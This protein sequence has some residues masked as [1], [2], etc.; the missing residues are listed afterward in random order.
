[1]SLKTFVSDELHDLVGYS[2]GTVADFIVATA[3]RSGSK[4]QLL[5]SLTGTG[6]LSNSGKTQAFVDSLWSQL[7][8]KSGAKTS[9]NRQREQEAV[10][11]QKR[12]ASYALLDDDDDFGATTGAKRPKRK[13]KKRNIRQRGTAPLDVDDDGVNRDK[14]TR[15]RKKKEMDPEEELRLKEE[16]RLRDIA[17]RDALADRLKQKDKDN[18]TNIMVNNSKRALEEARKRMELAEADRAAIVPELRKAARYKYLGERKDIKM[19]ELEA[20]IR[21]E[22]VLF[23]DSMTAAERK[24]LKA[25]KETLRLAKEHANLES[26]LHVDAYAMPEQYVNE[27]DQSWDKKKQMAVLKRR[28]EEAPDDNF[29]GNPEQK[30]WEDDLM[31]M[32]QINTGAK[33]AA[34]MTQQDDYELVMEDMSEMFV[35]AQT[36]GGTIDKD[37][38]PQESEAERRAKSIAEVRKSLPVFGYREAFLKAV[39]EYQILIIVGETGSGKTTQLPQYLVEEGYC[40][41]GKKIG[42][43]QPRRVA[44]MS[45]AARVSEEMGTK[46][47]MDVGYSIRFED[48]TSQRTKLKYMTDGMLLR[49]FLGEP[50][51][52]SY[53]VMM[54][55]EAHERTLHTDILFGLVKDIARFRSDLK[56]LISSAT[57]DAEKFSAYFD[58]APVFR[59]PGR[60]FPVDIFYSKAPEAD[61]LDAAVVT[62]LQ[63]HLSQPL[64]DILV[65]FTGQEEI[66]AAQEQLEEKTRKLGSKI[67]ELI[68]LPIYANLPSDMQAKIF[69]PTPP[70]ARKVVLA[71]NIAE[72]SLTIDNIIYVVDPGFSKQKSYNPRTGMESLLVTPCSQASANQ[73]SGRAGRVAAGKCFRLYTAIA[74]QNELEPN[75]IPEIQRTHLGNVVLLLK[76]LGIND[77]IHFDFMDPPPSETLIRALEQLYALGALNDRGELTKLGRRMAELPVEPMMS[78]ML[79][80]S[81]KYGVVEEILSITAML[82]TGGALFYRPKDKGVHA[83][84]ARENFFRPGGD[85]LTLLNVWREYEETNF[86]TQWCFENYI[87]HRSMRR[88]RDVRDQ[89]A[90][91]MERIEIEPSSNPADS[92]AIRK[93][94]TSGY[95]Y[96]TAR[97]GKG[98]TYRTVKHQQNVSIHPQSSLHKSLPRWVLYHE[99]VFTTKEYLRQ[100][101]EIENTW[102]LEVAPHYYKPKDVADEQNKKMPKGG[103]GR[104]ADKPA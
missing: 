61:Y 28:Y 24:R 66:E 84:N 39:E 88:A 91:L 51:L 70:G 38:K 69:E 104:S 5:S 89:L 90:G 42:C 25:K 10:A 101:I 102:L 96:N 35:Q 45:V 26:K 23:G 37:E 22:E 100:V 44:A 12:N 31:H 76:S 54:I 103:K 83:D 79:I 27:R 64:G 68:V 92:I 32:A 59:I 82:N 63:I 1:M 13:D 74:Y 15:R 78:K 58:D 21:D 72:T 16:E 77:L 36:L 87:Q 67:N 2:D 94:I 49:E 97:L 99:L 29:Q 71:T 86:S 50:D 6:T 46:L 20:E 98:G 43:T 33:D 55:D 62:I 8:S 18:T 17:E 57:M 11:M 65:F 41:E 81:E 52:A 93:A 75:T 47:G 30:A 48:C 14:P 9:R 40:D 4:E 19:D 56:L 85:H 60:R 7:P 53:N 3:K 80:A 34:K 95:F 73:R